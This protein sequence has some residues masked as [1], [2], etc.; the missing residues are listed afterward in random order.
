[1]SYQNLNNNN[2]NN[3]N[4]KTTERWYDHQPATVTE[5]NDVT[6]LWD[7]PIQ[8]DREIKPTD[9]ILS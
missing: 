4:T 8:T 9:L 6:I 7:M 1:M 5:N 2:N 3:Y